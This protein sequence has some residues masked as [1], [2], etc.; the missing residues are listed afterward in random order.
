LQIVR[1][2][3]ERQTV[4]G[5]E[6]G[7]GRFD[8]KRPHTL[9]FPPVIG[10]LLVVHVPDASDVSRMAILLRPLDRFMLCLEC[11][12]DTVSVI[13]DYVIFDVSALLP[14]FRPGLDVNDRHLSLLVPLLRM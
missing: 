2:A 3:V 10:L 6:F 12:E 9:S 11:C 5:D 1:R 13:L 7:P 8:V 14:T 4:E